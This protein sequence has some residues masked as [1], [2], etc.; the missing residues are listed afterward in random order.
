[1]EEKIFF[2]DFVDWI[3]ERSYD[4]LMQSKEY[5]ELLE[6]QKRISGKMSAAL[7][8]DDTLLE[9][10]KDLYEEMNTYCCYFLCRKVAGAVVK[11]IADIGLV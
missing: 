5:K 8:G 1:M 3:N 7:G 11:I 6:I 9:K 4:E 2:E 10:Y